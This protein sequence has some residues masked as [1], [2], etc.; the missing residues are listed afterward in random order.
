VHYTLGGPYFAGYEHC[1][2]AA[3]WFAERESMLF[4]QSR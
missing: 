3:A 1:E 2:Y 4:A